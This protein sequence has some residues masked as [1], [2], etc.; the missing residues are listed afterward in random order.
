MKRLLT[1]AN[2][3]F[4][5]A[6]N[7]G[8]AMSGSTM[9][10]AVPKT[11]GEILEPFIQALREAHV[12]GQLM[13][14]TIADFRQRLG[15]GRLLPHPTMVEFGRFILPGQADSLE[16]R[17]AARDYP[18]GIDDSV[19]AGSFPAL[20]GDRLFV[21]GAAY[22]PDSVTPDEAVAWFSTQPY[23][24][25]AVEGL[26]GV[27]SCAK[28]AGITLQLPIVAPKSRANIR[29]SNRIVCLTANQNG[30]LHRYFLW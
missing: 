17:F 29:G 30:M 20:F 24:A 8:C 21:L 12:G 6:I 7:G 26:A 18:G 16:S 9:T 5:L 2:P 28:D 25:G 11:E 4:V 27:V 19:L 14:V 22:F 13:K 10:G 23:I 3:M 15:V 1:A